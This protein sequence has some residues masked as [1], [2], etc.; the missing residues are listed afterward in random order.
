MGA[1][2]GILSQVLATVMA[3]QWEHA[4]ACEGPL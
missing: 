1:G 2:K 3:E 4:G